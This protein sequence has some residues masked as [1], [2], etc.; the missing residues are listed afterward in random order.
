MRWIY[1]ACLAVSFNMFYISPVLACATCMA[2]D[3]T[4][5]TMGTEKP[6]KG[7]T[8]AG[9]DYLSRGESVGQ[10]GINE[11]ATDEE[12]VTYNFSYAI[13]ANWLIA[14]NLPSVTKQV[15]R[16][17]LSSVTGSGL[18]DADVSVRWFLGKGGTFGAHRLW[19]LQFGIR[20]PT[21]SEQKVNGTPIDIDAQ[22]GAG[23][24][25]PNIG[26][27]YGHYAMPWFLYASG[28]FNH[29][30]SEGYQGYQAG[31]VA[32]ATGMV[33]YALD[34]G[35]AAQFSLDGRYKKKDYFYD[36]PDNDSGGLLVMATLGA[37]WTPIEDF[38]FNVS[39]QIPAVVN[40]NG[41]QD[42]ESTLRIGMAYDF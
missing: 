39:Y 31:D 4:I 2:G 8:R 15:E 9:I 11:V 37:A 24:T 20:L 3:P 23:A 42:E 29:A 18:G 41:D 35:V 1:F 36:Q 22:P 13:S 30:V 26:I 21:S 28:Y 16:Y 19:G 40:L 38:V 32:L 17:D 25:I 5:T 6:F 34:H 27:W 7:R 14:A 12:R 33:Q 10:P